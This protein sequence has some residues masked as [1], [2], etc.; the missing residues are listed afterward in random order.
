MYIS[1]S[2]AYRHYSYTT[3]HTYHDYCPDPH[4]Y[5]YAYTNYHCHTNSYSSSESYTNYHTY[6]NSG[7]HYPRSHTP[8]YT[9]G[10]SF[11]YADACAYT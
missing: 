2:N 9:S 7:A 3:S 10:N 11:A 4:S 6:S 5:N 8:T 1:T